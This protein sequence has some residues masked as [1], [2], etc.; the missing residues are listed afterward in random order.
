MKTAWNVF[1]IVLLINVLVLIGLAAKFYVDGRIN[2]ERVG[3]TVEIFRT[4]IEE[5]QRELERQ[6]QAKT[7]ALEEEKFQTWLQKV[8]SGAVTVEDKIKAD[9]QARESMEQLAVRLRSDRNALLEAMKNYKGRMEL[10]QDRLKEQQQQFEKQVEER[11]R[12]Q[13]S[14]GFEQAIELYERTKPQQVKKMFMDLIGRSASGRGQVV[15]YLAAMQ[16]RK[17]AGVIREFKTNPEITVATQ[18]I[19]QLRTR[20]IDLQVAQPKNTGDAT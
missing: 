16:P 1:S 14:E 3:A 8:K 20:G 2:R 4:T 11:A 17:A 10:L 15:A 18:L 5:E 13:Q 6:E 12:Q 7:L 9:L 19:E